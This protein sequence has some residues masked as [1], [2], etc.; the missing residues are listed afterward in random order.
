MKCATTS[1]TLNPVRHS[2]ILAALNSKTYVASDPN[3]WMYDINGEK[4]FGD[5]PDY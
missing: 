5:H 3:A 2:L 4:G 1:L